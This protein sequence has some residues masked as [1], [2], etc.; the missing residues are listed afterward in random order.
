MEVKNLKENVII[1]GLKLPENRLSFEDSMNE[2]EAL[3]ES[4]GAEV[5]GRVDQSADRIDAKTYIGSGK[6]LEIKELAENMEADSIII[7]HE[8]SG[9]QIKNLEDTIEKKIID[10]T[11]LILDIFA[12]RA[13]SVESVL[14]VELAQ[15]NYRLPRLTGY[16]N[17]LSRTGGGIGTRGPGEQQ[18]ETDRRHIRRQISA[19]KD[20]L[21]KQVDNREITRKQRKS[22]EL[23]VVSLLGYT[24]AGKS[25]IMN[26]L[27]EYTGRDSEKKVY[28]DDRLFATLDTRHVRIMPQNQD[29]FILADTVGL[30]RDIPVNLIEAFKSTLEEIKYADL[31]LVILDSSSENLDR[32]KEAISDTISDLEVGH[33]PTIKVYN[34]M[35]MVDDS[36]MINADSKSE[37]S[38]FISALEDEGIEKLLEEIDSV[39]NEDMVDAKIRIPYDDPV[40][41]NYIIDNFNTS[42]RITTEDGIEMNVRFNPNELHIFERF[43]IKDDGKL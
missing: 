18:L 39:L 19:I 11:N 5:I 37:H 12:L 8:L 31:I 10:R 34:K 2:L 41:A 43:V 24:N 1:V 7:N 35:D 21:Q 6:A 42:D 30:I 4:A 9:S 15:A 33:I 13:K 16:R 28:A 40:A 20:R 14:Q 23:P 36:L 32:Q 26:R 3:A 25:T 38:I 27:I 22:S 29:S 17:Y